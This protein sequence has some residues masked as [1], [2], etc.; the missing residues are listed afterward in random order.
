MSSLSRHRCYKDHLGDS[1]FFHHFILYVRC[2]TTRPY[3]TLS[4]FFRGRTLYQSI[5]SS[6]C[7]RTSSFPSGSNSSNSGSSISLSSTKL[8]NGTQLGSRYSQRIWWQTRGSAFSSIRHSISWIRLFLALSLELLLRST[9]HL[10]INIQQCTW[11][12]ETPLGLVK[13][14]EKR[15]CFL[16]RRVKQMIIWISSESRDY[17]SINIL[18]EV[19]IRKIQIWITVFDSSSWFRIL[20][21]VGNNGC[22]CSPFYWYISWED[23]FLEE[24]GD[25]SEKTA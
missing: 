14:G 21:F 24:T 20:L 13:L 4:A 10:H 8:L 25:F 7:W 11:M 18:M 12:N 16:L 17:R 6:R 5:I 1:N 9:L 23:R 22:E 3:N 15:K 2:S 19:F